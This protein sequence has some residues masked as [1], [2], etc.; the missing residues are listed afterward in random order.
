[1]PFIEHAKVV[2]GLEEMTGA[3]IVVSNLKLP[4]TNENLIRK[5]IEDGYALLIQRKQGHDLAASIGDRMNH[6]LARMRSF[7]TR[8]PQCILL[9]IGTLNCMDN[10][11]AMIDGREAYAKYWSVQS[12]VSK[13]HD[14]GGVVE[15]LPRVSL[16]EQWLQLKERHVDEYL[17]NGIKRVYHAK[18]TMTELEGA[19][20]LPVEVHDGRNLL[21]ALPNV[22]VTTAQALWDEFNGDVASIL[23]WLT[24]PNADTDRIKGIGAKTI[25]G[26][27]EFFGFSRN[28]LTNLMR[29]QLEVINDEVTYEELGNVG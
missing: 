8:Q 10:G 13:W 23:C 18:P 7:G 16:L 27:R 2:N 15:F 9:F 14:R 25:E 4:M 28:E 20:Q 17:K 22:G 21:T 24:N 26:V 6:S 19:L 29:L 11:N 12:A 1:M 3:D 5:H